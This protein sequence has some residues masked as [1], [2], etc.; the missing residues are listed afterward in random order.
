MQKAA[1]RRRI[2]HAEGRLSAAFWLLHSTRL[3]ALTRL[4]TRVALADHKHF[5]AAAHDF[6]ITMTRLGRLE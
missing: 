1:F 5:A 3:L 4:E 6:A 2:P